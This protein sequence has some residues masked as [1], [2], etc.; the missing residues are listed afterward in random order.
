MASDTA[1]THAELGGTDGVTRRAVIRSAAGAVAA[2]LGLAACGGEDSGDSAGPRAT[3]QPPP[4]GSG[5]TTTDGGARG[6]VLAKTAEVPVGSGRVV[7]QGEDAIV[8]IQETQ[9]QFTAF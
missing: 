9:G 8:V 2:G 6:Q 5:D 1:T 4:G 3:S 7:G